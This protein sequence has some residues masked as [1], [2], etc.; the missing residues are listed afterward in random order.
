MMTAASKMAA[1]DFAYPMVA[2]ECKLW[3]E[4]L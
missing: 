3:T 4:V 1:Q 2:F